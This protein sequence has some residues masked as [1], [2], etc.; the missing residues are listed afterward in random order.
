MTSSEL[1]LAER[2]TTK[3]DHE[4]VLLIA[5]GAD[6]AARVLGEL[7]SITEERFHLEWVT[8]L[9]GGIERLAVAWGGSARPEPHRQ[10][11]HRTAQ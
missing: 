5:A 2:T 9:S 3:S 4:C 1:K 10:P 7:G 6:D 11:S 8:E